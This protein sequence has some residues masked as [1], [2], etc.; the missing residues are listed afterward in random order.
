MLCDDHFYLDINAS[1][2]FTWLHFQIRN[3]GQLAGTRSPLYRKLW[4]W[5]TAHFFQNG[6]RYNEKQ[7]E[8]T[9]S[10]K[11]TLFRQTQN[12]RA[13]AS[14]HSRMTKNPFQVRN[15][16]ANQEVVLALNPEVRPPRSAP[17]R[18]ERTSKLGEFIYHLSRANP[19]KL[20]RIRVD[21]EKLWSRR[22]SRK[23]HDPKKSHFCLGSFSLVSTNFSILSSRIGRTTCELAPKL[24]NFQRF[25]GKNIEKFVTKSENSNFVDFFR[26][27]KKILFF[28]KKSILGSSR[29]VLA[30]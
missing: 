9:E 19:P 27:R 12:R 15:P 13:R 17:Y 16:K 1:L 2:Y 8:N 22:F 11:K 4:C 30:H 26:H 20:G 29:R 14:A 10:T 25:D 6:T 21:F 3:E 24:A 5:A 18:G 23:V 28:Y 7:R